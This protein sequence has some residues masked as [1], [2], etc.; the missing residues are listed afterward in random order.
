VPPFPSYAAVELPRRVVSQLLIN[1]ADTSASK[2]FAPTRLAR[3]SVVH[4]TAPTVPSEGQGFLAA[5][6]APKQVVDDSGGSLNDSKLL[7]STI[8]TSLDM[9]SSYVVVAV[10]SSFVCA[11]HVLRCPFLLPV[12]SL[13]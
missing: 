10:L 8:Q 1:L 11:L 5:A 4:V 12:R 3:D 13:Q 7:L 2:D 9:L 6:T